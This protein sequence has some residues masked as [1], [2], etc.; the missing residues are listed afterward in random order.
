MNEDLFP[1]YERELLYVGQLA[2]E[3]AQRHPNAA[4]RLGLE[5]TGAADPF[6]Q[7]L[8]QSFALLAGRTHAKI[9]DDYPELTDPLFH[10]L[11]PHFLAPIPSLALVE[12][13]LDWTRV[14]MPQGFL[15]AAGSPLD[16]PGTQEPCKFRTCYPVTLWP[17]RLV[18]ARFQAPPFPPGS[19][20]PPGAQAALRLELECTGELTFSHLQI[21][22]LRFY[23][24]GGAHVIPDL[25]EVLFNE[26]LQVVFQ[27]ERTEQGRT[28]VTLAPE[29]C[30]RPVGFKPDEGLLPYP[31]NA[32]LG[33]RLLTEFFAYPAKFQFLDLKGWDH[34]AA[35]GLG[36]KCEVVIYCKRTLKTLEQGVGNGTFRLGCTPVVNLFSREAESINLTRRQQEYR[37]MI[38]HTAPLTTEIYSVDAVSSTDAAV[39]RTT[40][41]PA[42]Q[43]LAHA[44]TDFRHGIFW[45]T[46]RRRS[47]REDDQGTEVYISLVNLDFEPNWPSDETLKVETTCT[48]RDLPLQLEAGPKGVSMNLQVPAPVHGVKCLRPPTAPLRPPA[49]RGGYWRLVSHLSPSPLSL[50]EGPAGREAL[51]DLLKNYDFSDPAAGQKH[52][53]DLALQMINGVLGVRHR[54]VLGRIPSDLKR[55]FCRGVEVILELDRDRFP[56]TGVF[57]FAQVMEHFF[58]LYATNNSFTRLIART[59]QAV[60]KKWAARTG[61]IPLL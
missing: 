25:Y 34:V 17:I 53:A 5:A 44:Q 45:Y 2:Q 56:G 35:A 52:L 49:R 48:N 57:L 47:L 39:S 26:A 7:R 18:N 50:Q 22:A 23:L 8:L 6:V 3:F 41:Y 29:A 46:T 58:G 51:Q 60:L 37:V 11:Y 54:R 43:E 15:I 10:F 33:Y 31:D 16:A 38:D 55:G 36:K 9:E 61:D 42:F 14:Q 27:S 19:Q 40:S 24:F 32:R 28:M 59:P 12:F 4:A 13:D 21:D 30:L 20:P 1:Y